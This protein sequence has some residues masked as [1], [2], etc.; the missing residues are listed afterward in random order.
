MSIL[1]APVPTHPEAQRK[2]RQTA[3]DA[4]FQKDAYLSTVTSQQLRDMDALP[5]VIAAVEKYQKATL[6]ARHAAESQRETTEMIQRYASG[7][8]YAPRPGAAAGGSGDEAQRR[9][10]AN[11][12]GLGRRESGGEPMEEVE[13]TGSSSAAGTPVAPLAPMELSGG[14]GQTSGSEA[15]RRESLGAAPQIDPSRDPRRRR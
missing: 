12:A 4:D 14:V 5:E 1:S 2:L 13:R 15:P 9:G 8:Y 3:K 10:S 7:N 6:Y 11:S